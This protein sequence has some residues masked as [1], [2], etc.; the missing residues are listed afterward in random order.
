M[1]YKTNFDYDGN[2]INVLFSENFNKI[3]LQY[4]II[5]KKNNLN[6]N[7]IFKIYN[8]KI[9]LPFKTNKN[10]I[11]TI[12]ST[13]IN[14]FNGRILHDII[15]NGLNYELRLKKNLDKIIISRFQE[16][17]FIYEIILLERKC[18]ILINK[19][20]KILENFA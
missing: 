5:Y 16:N 2:L 18:G 6:L 4:E 3:D 8:T 10:D 7:L 19:L 17:E 9:Q 12:V 13:L 11:N 1:N 20:G 15:L 14:I